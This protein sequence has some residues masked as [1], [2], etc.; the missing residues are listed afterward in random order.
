MVQRGKGTDA[1]VMLAESRATFV[2]LAAN[3]WIERTD[4]AAGG[5]RIAPERTALPA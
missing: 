1:D 4:A 3:P 5:A 2:E